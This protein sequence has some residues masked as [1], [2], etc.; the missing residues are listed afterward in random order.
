MAQAFA[1]TALVTFCALGHMLVSP[2][3]REEWNFYETLS[4]I[5]T[6]CND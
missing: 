4:L 3:E 2:Y 5:S 6:W 1:C